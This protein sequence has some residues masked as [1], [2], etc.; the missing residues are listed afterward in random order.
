[1]KIARV[2][3]QLTGDNLLSIIEEFL[4]ISGL[5][6]ESIVIDNTIKIKG[7]INKKVN[8]NFYGEIEIEAVKDNKIYG[9]VSK[10]KAMNLGF[11]RMF[12][13]I[14]LKVMMK[15]IPI[16]GIEVYKDNIIID[17]KKILIG[18]PYVDV[19]ISDLFIKKDKLC[20]EVSDAEISIMGTLIKKPEV[21]EEEEDKE[22]EINLNV[23]KINDYYSSGREELINK[24]PKE[25]KGLSDYLFVVPDI[26]ALIYRLLKDNRVS[27]KT[28]LV[29]SAS[30][31]YVTVPNDLIPK[32]IPL[33][34]KIDDLAVIFFALNRVANDVSLEILL[35][36]WAGKNELVLVLKNGLEYIVNFT[37]AKNI[38]K[39]CNMIEQLKTL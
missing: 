4:N 20:V 32:K 7:S 1:M 23:E 31:A 10:F 29:I 35:E 26:V 11:F 30:V 16:E 39:L 19:N 13:S 36:N 21:N 5:S 24:L 27:I 34:G 8:I 9:K 15:Y 22:K 6:L 33:I 3:A 17:V 37:G 25:V 12:R 2:E 38:D 14:G 28:K 18:V